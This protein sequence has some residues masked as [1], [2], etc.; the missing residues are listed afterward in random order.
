MLSPEEKTLV[1]NIRSLIAELNQ[2]ETGNEEALKEEEEHMPDPD[3]KEEKDT[4]IV[5]KT[6][7][8]KPKDET[9]EEKKE[10]VNKS[11][12][13][14]A[15]DDAET[16]LEDDLPDVTEDNLKVLKQ[17]IKAGR[18]R[19]TTKQERAMKSQQIMENLHT[20]VGE[21]TKVVKSLA[22]NQ[23]EHGQA[24]TGLI[25]GLGADVEVKKSQRQRKP[26]TQSPDSSNKLLKEVQNIIDQANKSRDT[27][28]VQNNQTADVRKGLK[29]ALHQLL[30]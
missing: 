1:G 13:A 25:Q 30:S 16:R 14:T 12:G 3:K 29:S 4:S 11:E 24:I 2:I 21:L 7:I 8:E 17:L 15:D 26:I 5:D 27:A 10:D 9:E 20:A 28:I 19:V 6:E 22:I 18:I 23:K